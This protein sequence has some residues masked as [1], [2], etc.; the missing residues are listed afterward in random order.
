[1]VEKMTDDV[2]KYEL[3]PV[4]GGELPQWEAGAHLDIVV[5][6]EFLRQYSMSGD[7]ANRS[8]YQ[9]GVLNEPEG[10]G[11]SALLHRIFSEGRKIFISRP[12]NHFPLIE[13]ASMTYLFGGGIGIT[14]MIAMAHRLH[15]LG[16]P[17]QMHYSGRSR[18]TMGYL[19]DLAHVAWAGNVTLHVTDEG[20]R[21]NLGELLSDPTDGA[22]V[23][24]CGAERFMSSVMD[25]AQ[26]AGIPEER[27]HLEYF[28]VP[29]QP[30]YENHPFRVRLKDG[31]ELHVSENETLSD[32]LTAN[33]IAVD[34]KCSDG[35]C[36][37]CKCGLVAGDV[38][39]RDFVLSKAQRESSLI[40]CQSRALHPDGLLELDI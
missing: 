8:V 1:M 10:R 28:S 26:A 13:T 21:A 31:R 24:T 37:V 2:T 38:E 9:I 6:P 4:D 36:G 25:A 19:H 35:I 15:A 20:S 29:E 7:P 16:Q 34:V 12:I 32:V 5:A 27:R 30:D 39:H 40:T 33:G 22:H 11:G 3:K 23:Y 18:A 17:F 14:P